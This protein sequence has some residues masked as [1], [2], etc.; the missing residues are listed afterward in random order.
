MTDPL[1]KLFGSNARVKLLRLFLFNS[2]QSFTVGEAAARTLVPALDAKR[3][4][5]LL[6]R[7]GVIERTARGRGLRYIL[8][9]GLPYLTPLQ[10]LL[11]NSSARGEDLV[12]RLRGVGSLKF[13]VV[14]G[15][16]VGEWDGRL[17]VLLAGDRVKERILR[18]RMRRLEAELGR[19]LRYA[20]LESTDLLYRLTVSDKLLRDVFDY[21][22]HIVLDKLGTGLS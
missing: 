10:Q 11:L 13:I 1:A 7:V 15:I 17:D 6:L 12:E 22:H 5:E 20:L 19:E 21:P 2:R 8:S 18:E 3:E 14:A 4:I 16:F 9:A